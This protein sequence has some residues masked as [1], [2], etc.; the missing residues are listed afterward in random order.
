MVCGAAN[1]PLADDAAGDALAARGIEYVPD[2]IANAG[3]VIKGASD[4]LGQSDRVEM[5]LAA[6]AERVREVRG[7]AARDGVGTHRAVVRVAGELLARYR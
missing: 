6:V 2:V 4:A 1:N 5:R 7:R 3:A